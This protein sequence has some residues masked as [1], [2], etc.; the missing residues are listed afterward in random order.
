MD[1]SV[2][3]AAD[4]MIDACQRGDIPDI[5]QVI[6]DLVS[7]SALIGQTHCMLSDKQQHQ[8]KYALSY[9]YQRCLFTGNSHRHP[10]LGSRL[11]KTSKRVK[12][13]QRLCQANE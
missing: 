13:R 11:A 1:G 8:L 12:K 9:Q 6:S 10:S 2:A 3:A 5:T 4:H 7:V